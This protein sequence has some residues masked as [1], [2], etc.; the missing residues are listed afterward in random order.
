MRE[1][2]TLQDGLIL[3]IKIIKMIIQIN[4]FYIYEIAYLD[5]DFRIYY[6]LYN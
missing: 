5:V 1:M 3:N 6:L 4:L 2:I